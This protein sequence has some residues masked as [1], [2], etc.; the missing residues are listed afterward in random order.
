MMD[1]NGTRIYLTGSPPTSDSVI[2]SYTEAVQYLR[3]QGATV[4][5]PPLYEHKPGAHTITVL[6]EITDNINGRPFYDYLAQLSEWADTNAAK[7]ERVVAKACGI[8]PFIV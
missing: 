2:A 4:V 3:K 5:H 7:L 1:V 6:H 8:K